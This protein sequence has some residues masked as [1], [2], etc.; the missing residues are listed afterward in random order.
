MLV[1]GR[2][3]SIAFKGASN[4]EIRGAV[5]GNETNANEPNSYFEFANFTMGSMKLRY[6]KANIDLALRG[7]YSMTLGVYREN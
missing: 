4:T 5:I 3:V 2:N 6:G 1:T 7:L